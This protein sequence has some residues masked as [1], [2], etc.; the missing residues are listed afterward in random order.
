MLILGFLYNAP[1]TLTQIN[2]FLIGYW[3]LWGVESPEP[4][5]AGGNDMTVNGPVESSEA[6]P[7]W[8]LGTRQ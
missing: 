5:M 7:V 3:P 6:P 4:D 2:S 8:G 1:I